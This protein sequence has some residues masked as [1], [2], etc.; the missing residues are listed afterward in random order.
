MSS[1]DLLKPPHK[2]AY[3]II[4]LI[5]LWAKDADLFSH[6]FPIILPLMLPTYLHDFYLNYLWEDTEL[7][8]RM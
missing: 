8:N 6:F 3:F 4:E 5:Q 1:W 7:K 2:Y